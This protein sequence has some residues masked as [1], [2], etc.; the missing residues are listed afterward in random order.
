P[1]PLRSVDPTIPLGLEAIVTKCLQPDVDAR[2][3]DMSEVTR[4]LESFDKVSDP[5]PTLGVRTPVRPRAATMRLWAILAGIAALVVGAWWVRNGT[6]A[7]TS[8]SSGRTVT[9]AVLPF[10]NV[11]SDSSLTSLGESISDVLRTELG[12][13]SAVR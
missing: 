9:L 10:R 3:Q 4:E 8:P 12:H 1:T 2:Y 13:S 7:P 6:R 5:S 11:S